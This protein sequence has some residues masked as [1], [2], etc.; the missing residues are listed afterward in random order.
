MKPSYYFCIPTVYIINF[1][2]Y[3]LFVFGKKLD[4]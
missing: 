4:N 1:V 3:F 2:E